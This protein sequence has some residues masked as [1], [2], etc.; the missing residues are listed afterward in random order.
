MWEAIIKHK[1]YFLTVLVIVLIAI[2]INTRSENLFVKYGF[3][4]M[5]N[6]LSGSG[7][8]EVKCNGIKIVHYC[9]GKVLLIPAF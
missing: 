9:L 5:D 4:N 7:D 8:L 6:I 2:I 3:V 1:K